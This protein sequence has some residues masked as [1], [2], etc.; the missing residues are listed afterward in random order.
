MGGQKLTVAKVCEY[1]K[2]DFM[3][4]EWRRE[5]ARYCSRPCLSEGKKLETIA[6]HAADQ[7]ECVQCKKPFYLKPS[8][9]GKA[10]SLGNCCSAACVGEHRKM[11]YIGT[12]N[13]NWRGKGTDSDG[14]ALFLP[15]LKPGSKLGKMKAHQAVACEIL[16]ISKMPYGIHIHHRD[17]NRLNNNSWNLSL[18][19]PS[20]HKWLHHQFTK[21]ELTAYANGDIEVEDM[22]IKS[23]NPF[24]AHYLLILDVNTQAEIIKMIGIKNMINYLY[25]SMPVRATLEVVEEFTLA[26]RI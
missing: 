26:G 19:S 12:A 5:K 13:P 7:I 8:H 24:K 18:M 22:I 2:A 3:V 4:P 25:H 10:N 23:K 17:C 11:A 15:Q 6:R 1:C 16:G 9:R 14:Y 21:A 20:N